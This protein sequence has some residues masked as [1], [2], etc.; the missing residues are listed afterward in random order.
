MACGSTSQQK[1]LP[2]LQVAFTRMTSIPASQKAY[3]HI[4]KHKK[5]RGPQRKK[6]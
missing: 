1:V 5:T 2:N 6:E 3:E 4:K